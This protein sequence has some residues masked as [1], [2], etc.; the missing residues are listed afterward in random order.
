MV[1]SILVSTG[2]VPGCSKMEIMARVPSAATGGSWIIENNPG[3][4]NAVMVARTLVIPTNQ[5][6]PVRLLNP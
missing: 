2:T 6:V 4:S 5:T 1:D 3:N